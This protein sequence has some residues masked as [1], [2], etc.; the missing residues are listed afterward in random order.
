MLIKRLRNPITQK[1]LLRFKEVKRAYLSF[2][3]LICLYLLSL[4]AE[5]ICNNTPLYVR[6]KGK[7]Y[8]PVFKYYPEDTFAGNGKKTRSNYHKINRQPVFS[9]N[10][11]NFMVSHPF[12]TD[13]M[14]ALIRNPSR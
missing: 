8:F 5:L 13:P 9:Q 12:P 7:S 4:G 14:K 3:I 6:F 10:D 11:A 1:R 2:W